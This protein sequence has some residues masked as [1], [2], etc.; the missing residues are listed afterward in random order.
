MD[1]MLEEPCED[2]RDDVW[3]MDWMREAF[4]RD[5][6]TPVMHQGW[7]LDEVAA[8]E[9]TVQEL[10]ENLWEGYEDW[11]DDNYAMIAEGYFV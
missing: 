10:I 2:P 1:Y 7:A 6:V 9:T 8:G 5:V 11:C 4:Q 3:N